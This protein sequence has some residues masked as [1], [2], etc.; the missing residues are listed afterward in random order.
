MLVKLVYRGTVASMRGVAF[1]GRL[2]L[3]LGDFKPGGD[4]GGCPLVSNFR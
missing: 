2:R 3:K 1:D 4:R